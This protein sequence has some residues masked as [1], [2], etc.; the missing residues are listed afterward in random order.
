MP[1][2]TVM[3]RSKLMLFQRAAMARAGRLGVR[4]AFGGLGDV[5]SDFEAVFGEGAGDD[6]VVDGDL[7]PEQYDA[8]PSGTYVGSD[9]T[10]VVS[11][12]PSARDIVGGGADSYAYSATDDEAAPYSSGNAPYSQNRVQTTTAARYTGAR[13][14]SVD[15]GGNAAADFGNALKDIF[16]SLFGGKAEAAPRQQAPA[17]KDFPWGWV[18]GGVGVVAGVGLIVVL[19]KGSKK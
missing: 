6:L 16:G 4:G 19:A 10:T 3:S 1:L 12:G 5:D 8:A 14:S 18:I 15:S 11:S 13:G 7:S 17:K 2:P 9:S